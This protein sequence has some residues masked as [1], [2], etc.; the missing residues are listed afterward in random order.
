ML[1]P[2]PSTIQNLKIAEPSNALQAVEIQTAERF[3]LERFFFE[4]LVILSVFLYF[5]PI[6]LK[7][8]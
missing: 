6:S 7:V 2:F 4:L 1:L 8:E 3:F 5:Q